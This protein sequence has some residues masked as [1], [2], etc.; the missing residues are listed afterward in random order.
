MD[1]LT[2]F[3]R[4]VF[5][6][7][8]RRSLT[9]AF[10]VPMVLFVILLVGG[11]AALWAL[12]LPALWLVLVAVVAGV[13]LYLTSLYSFAAVLDDS[14]RY[15][16]LRLHQTMTDIRTMSWRDF[17]DLVEAYLV[18]RGFDVEHQGRDTADGGVDL[19]ARK[20]GTKWLVQCKH[21]RDDWVG[22]PPLR[23][24]LGLVKHRDANGGFLVACGSFDQKAREF[25]KSSPEI[26]LVGG[27]QLRSLVEKAVQSRD[28][29]TAAAEPQPAQPRR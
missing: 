3:E 25:V 1:D 7:F 13:V 11:T 19:V 18:D 28:A 29:K 24:L 12:Q 5:T 27:E 6:W 10:A 21:Y 15:K 9:V 17:E 26:R 20:H 2:G 16:L 8:S 23:E 4:A 14:R 22:E